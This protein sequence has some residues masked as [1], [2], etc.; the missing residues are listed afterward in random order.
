[1]QRFDSQNRWFVAIGLACQLSVGGTVLAAELRVV[2]YNTTSDVRP[3][4]SLVLEAIGDEIV[5]GVARPIDLLALQEQSNSASDTAEIVGLLNN[6]YGLGTYDRAVT[7]GDSN[8]G[9]RPGL[10]FNTQTVE[11][12]AE[13]AIGTVS[14]SGQVRQI[15]RYKIRPQGYN[16]GAADFYLYNTHSKSGTGSTNQAR[17]L[18]ESQALRN[19]LDQLG[20]GVAAILAGDL[21]TRS[22]SEPGYQELLSPGT[23]QLFDPLDMSASWHCTNASSCTPEIR[24]IHTQ[25]TIA[26]GTNGLIGGG[27]DDRF[28]FQL[29][30]DTLLNDEGI[31]FIDGSYHT[32][33]NNGTHD[34][35]NHDIS[36]GTGAVPDILAALETA[37]DHLPVIA[38]YRLPPLVENLEGDFN[39][40][41]FVDVADYTVWRDGLGVNYEQADYL[42][43]RENFNASNT[44]TSTL[45]PEPTGWLILLTNAC[46]LFACRSV[47]R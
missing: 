9:G 26:T 21:N 40:D 31:F 37:S 47:A 3:G 36:T 46:G 10:V 7:D 16:D 1:M 35:C 41:G 11:L 39:Q 33:G 42:V 24:R 38:D 19:D 23:G 4:L 12:L 25:S 15:L 34:C 5:N 20:A 45:V 30:T 43:W 17:R 8:G 14:T 2:T 29:V 6:I 44:A 18:V 27:I 13:L 32:F 28:D 22:S